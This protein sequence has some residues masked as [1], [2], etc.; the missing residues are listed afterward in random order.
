MHIVWQTVASQILGLIGIAAI[1]FGVIS[2]SKRL[3]KLESTVYK[4]EA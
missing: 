1:A 2:F 4:D 3:K